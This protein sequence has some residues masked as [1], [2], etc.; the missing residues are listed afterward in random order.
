[1][2]DFSSRIDIVAQNLIMWMSQKSW[3][4]NKTQDHTVCSCR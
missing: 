2:L 1:M 3:K 4:W